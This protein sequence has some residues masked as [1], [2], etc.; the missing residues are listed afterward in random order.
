MQVRQS[1]RKIHKN[2]L[3]GM[4]KRKNRGPAQP[5]TRSKGQLMYHEGVAA[6]SPQT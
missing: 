3:L 6:A 1:S 4:P 2:D 5:T